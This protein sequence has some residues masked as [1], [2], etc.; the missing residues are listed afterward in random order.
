MYSKLG[1]AVQNYLI[2]TQIN[3]TNITNNAAVKIVMQEKSL[4]WCYAHP[5]TIPLNHEVDRSLY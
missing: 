4:L 2:L 3:K 5:L 1:L